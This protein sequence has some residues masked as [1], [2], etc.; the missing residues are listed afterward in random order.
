MD[1]FSAVTSGTKHKKPLGIVSGWEWKQPFKK[2]SFPPY[3]ASN[4]APTFPLEC[5]AILHPLLGTYELSSALRSLVMVQKK[6]CVLRFTFSVLG[7]GVCWM[8]PEEENYFCKGCCRIIM[9]QT[10]LGVFLF[11]GVLKFLLKSS[12]SKLW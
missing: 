12:M 8:V 9:P 1:T 3:T 10:N 5:V 11:P 6:G 4:V 2:T 7:V